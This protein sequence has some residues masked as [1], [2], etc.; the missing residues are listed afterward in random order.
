MG[1]HDLGHGFHD[2]YDRTRRQQR[3]LHFQT[4]RPSWGQSTGETDYRKISWQRHQDRHCCVLAAQL[5]MQ[6]V[7]C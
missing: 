5:S 3:C 6:L 2:L 7:V 4:G 1:Q